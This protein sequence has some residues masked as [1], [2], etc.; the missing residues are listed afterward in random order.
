MLIGFNTYRTAISKLGIT[1]SIQLANYMLENYSFAMLPGVDFGF[2]K[3]ELFFRIAF[4]DFNGQK[5]MKAFETNKNI[6][7]DFIKEN[8]PSIIIGAESIKKFIVDLDN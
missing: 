2:E 7:V 4:V 1:T 6:D 8:A 3:E 5:V